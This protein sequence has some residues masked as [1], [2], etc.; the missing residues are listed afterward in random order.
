MSVLTKELIKKSEEAAVDSKAFTYRELM[1]IAGEKA[2]EIINERLDIVDRKVTVI[3]GNGNNGGDGFVIARK[4]YEHGALVKVMTPLGNPLTDDAK[5]Y[6][7]SLF[8]I[9]KTEELEDDCDIIIDAVFGIGLNRPLDKKL[10]DLFEKVNNSKAF[11]VSVDIPSGIEAN[12]GKILGSAVKADLTVTFIALKPCFLLPKGSDYCGEVVVADINVKPLSFDYYTNQ[13]PLFKKREHNSH[14]GTFGTA[15][16]F[17]GSYGMAGAAILSA[18]AALRSGVGIAKCVICKGIYSAF[19][20][21]V[22][23]AVCIPTKQNLKGTLCKSINLNKLLLKSSAVL[24]GCG[25]G[26]SNDL[27]IL[28]K[29]L[30]EKSE[31]PIVIDADGINLLS[32]NINLLKKAKA[33][34]ILTPHPAEMA[35]LCNTSVKEIEENR[36][37]YARRFAKENN[38]ILVL[39]G[40]NTIIA[41]PDG[42][43]TFNLNGNPGMATAGSGDVLSGIT[44]SLLSQGF[45]PEEAAKYAVFFHGEAGDKA[46]E[47][48]NERSMLAGDIIEML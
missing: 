31:V 10:C 7:K 12:T 48:R 28:L 14:K 38:C 41:E 27:K 35:R 1:G 13:K 45:S 42:K 20:S 18:K 47:I 17:C 39:K 43:I 44:V 30:L 40:A 46:L 22:P 33:P 3:C 23:E 9:E 37:N 34:V 16:L 11:R 21:C 25:I 6:F 24:F 15:L 5:F 26:I 2:F 8:P 29:N 32:N 4:L 19:T 36:I